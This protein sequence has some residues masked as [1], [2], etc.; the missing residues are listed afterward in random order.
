[1]SVTAGDIVCA[2]RVVGVAPSDTVL[3]HSSMKSFGKV[4]GG[5]LAVIQAAKEAVTDKG[6]VVFP[7]LVQQDFA[8]AYRNWDICRS[9][10]DVGLITETFRQLPDSIRSDQ[11]THSVAAW[12][13]KA[14]DITGEHSAYGP[15]MGVFGDYCFSYSSP[16]QKMYFAE[17]RIV[18]IG[19]DTVYNT[20]KHF[21]EYLLVEHYLSSIA[22]PRRKCEAMSM[23][24][25]HNIAGVW[26]FHDATKTQALLE[27]RGLVTYARCGDSLLTSLKANDYVDQVLEAFKQDPA[28]WFDRAFLAW[29]ERYVLTS[30]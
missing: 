29:L 2:F 21:S 13:S 12:G 9:P 20:F 14:V 22:D 3:I 11:A 10:S 27:E 6:T 26:P 16:W 23:I 19:I 30:Y 5:P 7:T 25:R 28:V 15:R 8:N 24:A 17:A 1:M 18:F 4:E